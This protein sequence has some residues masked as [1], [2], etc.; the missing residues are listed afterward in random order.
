MRSGG[1]HG[2]IVSLDYGTNQSG[3]PTPSPPSESCNNTSDGSLNRM[4]TSHSPAGRWC[5]NKGDGLYCPAR[6]E[7]TVLAS[8]LE[9]VNLRLMTIGRNAHEGLYWS[10]TQYSASYYDLAYIVCLTESSYMG[11]PTDG[12]AINPRTKRAASAP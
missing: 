2:K 11:I 3:T 10:S 7:L 9:A 6:Y 12:P 5:A 1:L 8:A 4:P